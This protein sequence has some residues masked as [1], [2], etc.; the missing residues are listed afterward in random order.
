M[1]ISKIIS[2]SLRCSENLTGI[3]VVSHAFVSA[4][5][6]SHAVCSFSFGYDEFIF[7]TISV[8]NA[9]YNIPEQDAF[10]SPDVGSKFYS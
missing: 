3:Y 4:G 7:I 9:H 1:F 8:R 5:M 10:S 2:L 6:L